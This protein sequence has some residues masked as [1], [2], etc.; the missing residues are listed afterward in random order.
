MLRVIYPDK[1]HVTAPLETFAEHDPFAAFIALALQ[2]FRWE[3]PANLQTEG[4]SFHK[5]IKQA[6][7][8]VRSSIYFLREEHVNAHILH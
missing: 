5:E 6:D 2:G 8:R 1:T 3:L 4:N 7:S